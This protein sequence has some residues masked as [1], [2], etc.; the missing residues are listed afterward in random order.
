MRRAAAG[1]ET[2]GRVLC[3]SGIRAKKTCRTVREGDDGAVGRGN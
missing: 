2:N 1:T 3:V